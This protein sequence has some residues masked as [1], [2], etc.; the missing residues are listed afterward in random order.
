MSLAVAN[1]IVTGAGVYLG[2]GFCF[3]A[4]FVALGAP[5]IDPGAKGMPVRA[6]LLILPGV[7]LLWPLML[8]KWLTQS[9]PPA[10]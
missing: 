7:A 9:E 1:A 2:V 10:S 5:K 6:R 4:L 8:V 3:A